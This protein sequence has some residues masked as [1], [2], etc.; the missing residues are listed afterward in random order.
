MKSVK[1][2]IYILLLISV[3]ALMSCAALE[4]A[5]GSRYFDAKQRAINEGW[6]VPTLEGFNAL[7][8]NQQIAEANGY[9]PG[10]PN[11]PSPDERN[12]Q[13]SGPPQSKGT[14]EYL[15]RLVE[16]RRE[17]AQANAVMAHW[18]SPAPVPSD[19]P[20]FFNEW[21]TYR[22]TSTGPQKTGD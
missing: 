10:D 4:T 19:G 16:E 13:P 7:T 14:T 21:S 17:Q 8:T 11:W 2:L 6:P 15:Q 3:V 20:Y 1:Y 18:N 5:P 9:F 12:W 22:S